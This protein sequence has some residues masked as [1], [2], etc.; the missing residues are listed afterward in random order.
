MTRFKFRLQTPYDLASW[1]E[2]MAKQDV[3]EK[4]MVYDREEECLNEKLAGMKSLIDKERSLQGKNVSI[5]NMVMLK[6]L[7]N[8]SKA[9]VQMQTE[10]VKKA[11]TELEESRH[12]LKEISKE[13][14][15]MEKLRERRYARYLYEWRWQEQSAIDE[16]A[17]TGF[18]RKHNG[19]T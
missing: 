15:S 12:E 7:Q 8:L 4:Q 2:K 16:A 14:K 6:E 18:W 1:R 10:V 17:V 19:S 5:G 11:W 13:K 3:K 9:V